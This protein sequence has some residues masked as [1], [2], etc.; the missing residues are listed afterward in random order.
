[1]EYQ[2][3]GHYQGQYLRQYLKHPTISSA[4][5]QCSSTHTLKRQQYLRQYL[6]LL[7][8]STLAVRR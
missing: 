8:S 5:Q 7:D 3:W 2:G 1:L 4:I 6:I